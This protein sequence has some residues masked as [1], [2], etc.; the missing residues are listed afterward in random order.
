MRLTLKI[1]SL[2]LFSCYSTLSFGEYAVY[3]QQPVHCGVQHDYEGVAGEGLGTL[4]ERSFPSNANIRPWLIWKGPAYGRQSWYGTGIIVLQINVTDAPVTPVL[5]YNSPIFVTKEKIGETIV[6]LLQE[7]TDSGLGG[8]SASTITFNEKTNPTLGFYLPAGNYMPGVHNGTVTY[9]VFAGAVGS[10]I[11]K[12][13]MDYSNAFTWAIKHHGRLCI[14]PLKIVI[15]NSCTLKVNDIN[16]GSVN[17]VDIEKGL[18]V[19]QSDM[20]LSCLL[21]DSVKLTLAGGSF[22]D[23]NMIVDMGKNVVSLLSISKHG[24]D[25]VKN[26]TEIQQVTSKTNYQYKINSTLSPKKPLNPL[27]GG[28]IDGEAII[29]IEFN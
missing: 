4:V 21:N 6:G 18:A 25:V 11:N 7:Y 17:A 22:H 26:G 27:M 8:K 10:S 23:N 9:R 15:R 19:K 2:L 14:D 20:S 1:T 24:D 13:F 3:E 5:R 28:H 16:H 29:K 12:G